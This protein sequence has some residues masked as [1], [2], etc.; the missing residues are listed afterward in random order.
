[1]RPGA[2]GL[3][4][5]WWGSQTEEETIAAIERSLALGMNFLDT[6]PGQM[7][8]RWGKALAGGRRQEVF[9]QG[10]VSSCVSNEM[11]SDHSAAATRRSVENSLVSLR[12]DHLDSV[13][14]H[15]YD[16]LT[17]FSDATLEQVDPLG[18]GNALDELV[19]MRD[20]GLVGHIGIGARAAA[21]H[22]RA[23]ATGEIELILT[24]LE[25]NLLT[26]AAAS[27]LFPI[28]RK[29][30]TGVILAS[31]L[32]MGLLTGRQVEEG[33]ERR[34]IRD[35]AQ[36]RG[37]RM[38][39]WCNQRGLDIR[40]L[41]IQFCMAAPVEGIVLPGQASRE[42]VEGTHEAATAQIS[43][44]VWQEFGQEFGVDMRSVLDNRT[45]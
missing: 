33:D 15:G 6:Y 12:T 35:T 41:A 42:E 10:K 9:L 25:Y 37:A 3:G 29:T 32:G 7:E 40:H 16:Q 39:S 5:A 26:V 38:L 28:C 14:I 34:K 45:G 1:M 8:E 17:D 21:V 44:A 11:K 24:Y 18:P 23:I 13:L 27:E 22:Q 43:P 19:K 2:V 31:P 30:D 4:G 36:P 20:E